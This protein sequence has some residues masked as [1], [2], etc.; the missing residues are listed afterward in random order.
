MA[1]TVMMDAGHGGSDYGAVYEGRR[2]K[3]DTIRLAKEVGRILEDHGVTVGYTRAEDVYLTPFER[4]KLANDANADLFVS[5]HRNAF[6]RSG[7]LSGVESYIYQKGGLRE[8]A[9]K[10]VNAKLEAMGFDNLGV[11]ERPH[12]IVLKRTK[13]PAVLVQAGYIDSAKDN[14]LFD[15][16][17]EDIAFAIA[18]GIM[19]AMGVDNEKQMGTAKPLEMPAGMLM[20]EQSEMD[21]ASKPESVYRVQAGLF[22]LESNAERLQWELVSEGFPAEVVM[23]D[24]YYKVLV[25]EFTEMDAAAAM[26]QK[27]RE[28]GYA[29]LLI[30]RQR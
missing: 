5:L 20:N 28:Y 11:S 24:G 1:K 15:G 19:Q 7:V 27:L 10:V 17:M 16:A 14:T 3:D 6:P 29:T 12:L 21:S 23:E 13:M 30:K 18:D 2:E 9:A 4:A 25:G 26:E 22:R 8:Q